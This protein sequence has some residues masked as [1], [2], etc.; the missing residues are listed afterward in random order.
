MTPELWERLNP[1]FMEA[2]ERQPTERKAFIAAVCGDDAEL[3]NELSALVEAHEV[4]DA[5]IHDIDAIVRKIVTS[6]GHTT[7]ASGDLVL[8]RFRIVRPLGSGGM[9]DVYE[10]FDS[11]LSQTVALKLIRPEIARNDAI[12]ARFKREVQLA[13]R[14]S[15]P[16]ICRI[17]EL[18]VFKDPKGSNDGA[19]LTMEFLDGVT[20]ADALKHGSVS[21][22]DAEWIALDICTALTTV[23]AA[24]IIHRDLKSR[25]IMLV[26]RDGG[27]RAVVMDFGLAHEL[28]P[29]ETGETA[30]TV[31]GGFLGTPEC[32]APEQF[33]GGAITPATDIYAF[34]IVLYELATGMHP[35]A[36]PNA[37]GAA[38]LRGR[39]PT[40]V[41]SVNPSAPNR[42]DHVIQKCLE[43][44]PSNR[45]QSVAE[46]AQALRPDAFHLSN[47]RQRG[48]IP[49][50]TALTLAALL[51]IAWVVPAIRERIE[52]VVFASH[53]KHIA[54][55]PFDVSDN[56][57]ATALLGDGLMDSLTGQLS[58]L[59]RANDTLWV[60][61]ASEV[62]RR[63]VG[64]PRSALREFGATIVIKG[65]F[66]RL[67]HIVRLNLEL[68]DTRKMREIGFARI[69]MREDDLAALQDE[70]VKQLGRLM[71]ISIPSD[72]PRA[73]EEGVNGS[74]YE[75]YITALGYLERYDK[76]GNLDKAIASLSDAVRASPRFTSALEALGRAYT[77]KY[78]LEG[79]P[80]SLNIAREFLHRAVALEDHLPSLHA[81][82]AK[83]H[84]IQ[85]K[86]DLAAKEF[87]L[88][89]RLDPRNVGALTGLAELY[90]KTGKLPDAEKA[91][92]EA[93][94]IRPDDWQGYNLLGNFYDA[95]GRHS[96]AIAQF[97]HALTLTPDNAYVYS[98]LAGAYLNSSDHG[99]FSEAERALKK[100][101]SLNPSYNAYAS[102]GS[103][104]AMQQRFRESADATERALQMNDEDYEVWNNLVLAYEALGDEVK[105]SA[106][107]KRT[108]SLTE[109][110]LTVNPKNAEG[111]SML[112]SLL[113]QSHVRDGVLTNIRDAVALAPKDQ[114]VLEEV[115]DAYE[116]LG[117]RRLAIK[118][119]QAALRNGLPP[120]LIDTDIYL[121]KVSIDPQFHRP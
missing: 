61:P 40:P 9:G 118:Y 69:D 121:H 1:L 87:Q 26:S 91:Y 81:A 106:A 11:E 13:R 90:R 24:G 37:L 21:K 66:S 39:R 3:R 31:P 115:A 47:L 51:T 54:V 110:A 33:Q 117:E 84:T 8:G 68:I 88:V 16:N 93:A 6:P 109:R 4:R 41:S 19:F 77:L 119:L 82:L 98:N 103:L 32:C 116:C 49:L 114:S 101:I 48:S 86:Y 120:V 75:S 15:G 43:F 55:L 36:S 89:I 64:D 73:H 14:L 72:S 100:S 7:L 52:G 34:G 22:V 102:L 76:T 96:D 71:N 105:A 78:R 56:N 38:V 92:I 99:L 65:Y 23:H 45:F 46:V 25:N 85:G 60:I 113:A 42:W 44:E 28:S 30:L 83:L 17:H 35:F 112:A 67:N 20:L 97:Q 12:L 79:N 94:R 70:A 53:E 107:R 10:A 62:R 104:Y 18:F 95:I 2:V 59:D 27:R 63:K 50:L 5:A 29:R 58:N 80:D 74:S 108:I 111:H 57:Q